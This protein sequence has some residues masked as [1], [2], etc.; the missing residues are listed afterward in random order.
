MT[1]DVSD[2]I[3]KLLAIA[4]ASDSDTV[5]LTIGRHR[6]YHSS[7][8]QHRWEAQFRTKMRAARGIGV[9]LLEAL[10]DLRRTWEERT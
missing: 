1:A 5:V 2:E 9:T 4:H 8:R 10:V 3:A 7:K 6:V